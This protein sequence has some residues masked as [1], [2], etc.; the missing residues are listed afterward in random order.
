M[1]KN[2]R[3]CWAL[4]FIA[5]SSGGLTAQT[6]TV[7]GAGGLVYLELAEG[8]YAA[9]GQPLVVDGRHIGQERINVMV[10]AA[11]FWADHLIISEPLVIN[12][13]FANLMCSAAGAVLGSAGPAQVIADFHGAPRAKSWYPIGLANQLAGRDLMPGVADINAR[14]NSQIDFN[15]MPGT[16]WYYGVE[17]MTSPPGT[18]ALYNTAVHEIAHGL[19]FTTMMDAG[20]GLVAHGLFDHYMAHLVDVGGKALTQMTA[21]ERRA[22]AVSE[23]L[24]WHGSATRAEA[25]LQT[26]IDRVRM[27]APRELRRGSSLSHFSP[28][29][30][31]QSSPETMGPYFVSGSSLWLSLATLSDM[32]W[33]LVQR[34]NY[35]VLALSDSSPE[36]GAWINM[37][38]QIDLEQLAAAGKDR[39]YI[40]LSQG[41][42][43]LGNLPTD[44]CALLSDTNISCSVPQ[45]LQGQGGSM[46]MTIPVRFTNLGQARVR[47]A[48]ASEQ[49]LSSVTVSGDFV[50]DARVQV[51]QVLVEEKPKAGGAGFF[52][53]L[54]C[55]VV[56]VS[57]V[58]R[59][60]RQSFFSTTRNDNNY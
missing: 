10:A 27:H 48:A 47:L 55:A 31:E 3:H 19:G 5:V 40:D 4:L 15:C 30:N 6:L 51:R 17:A 21:D 28:V 52:L 29:I 44:A 23:Q 1:L 49:Q 60:R 18:F 42:L 41:Q 45:L 54:L 2:F 36:Q 38:A 33:G 32:G 8:F 20:T 25:H 43:R 13:R 56:G 35:F 12:V 50:V 34:S 46:A 59:L 57:W 26:G 11:K 58:T 53:L 22:A 7:Q 16:S 37:R 39:L 9:D 14:F 24:F